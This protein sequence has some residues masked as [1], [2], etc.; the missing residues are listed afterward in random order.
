MQVT[1]DVERN[2][3]V[4]DVGETVAATSIDTS[5][6]S[7]SEV[8]DKIEFLLEASRIQALQQGVL[9]ERIQVADGRD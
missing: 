7:E 8:I 5:N 2:R 3:L 6:M 9:E 4:F 1:V